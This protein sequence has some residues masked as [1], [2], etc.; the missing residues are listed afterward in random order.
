MHHDPCSIWLIYKHKPS[1]QRRKFGSAPI[2]YYSNSTAS[3]NIPLTVSGDI[4]SNPGPV[5]DPCGNCSR[6]GKCNQ[7]S[8]LCE[9]CNKFWHQKC[10]PEMTIIQY[11]ELISSTIDWFCPHC[12]I[13]LPF[14]SCSDT[15]SQDVFDVTQDLNST[16][17]SGKDTSRVQSLGSP[18]LPINMNSISGLL[19]NARSIRSKQ[20]QLGAFMELHPMDIVCL[21]K[22]G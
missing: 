13:T 8:L 21:L 5:K 6:P 4:E 2:Q 9:D 12:S 19:L 7:R 1:T 10:I 14:S 16:Q 17:A 22:L 15:S 11:T 20:C 18:P 3:F